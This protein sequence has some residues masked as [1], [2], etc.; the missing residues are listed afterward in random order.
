[1]DEFGVDE[2]EKFIDACLSIEDLIDI[3]SPFIKRPRKEGSV[4]L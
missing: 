1:M 2:V 4:R 3:H